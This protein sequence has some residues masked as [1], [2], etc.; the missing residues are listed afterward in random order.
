MEKDWSC[1]TEIPSVPSEFAVWTFSSYDSVD[2]M[3]LDLGV[4]YVFVHF[5]DIVV[6]RK[7]QADFRKYKNQ[8]VLSYRFIQDTSVNE[9]KFSDSKIDMEV[10]N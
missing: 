1:T 5:E 3:T 10:F 9:F 4:K 8:P 6:Q 7:S 2:K